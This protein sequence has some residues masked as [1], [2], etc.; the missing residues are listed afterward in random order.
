MRAYLTVM[1]SAI[2]AAA[3][4]GTTD[5]VDQGSVFQQ[6]EAGDTIRLRYGRSVSLGTSGARIVFRS[7]EADSRCPINVVCVWQGDAHIRLDG[8]EAAGSTRIDLHTGI[9]PHAAEFAGYRI[10]LLEVTPAPIDP[11]EARP[12]DYSVRLAVSRG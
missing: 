10:E 9:E 6:V 1:I 8:I 4:G 12:Q 3:C 7:I 11:P 5:P 2:A